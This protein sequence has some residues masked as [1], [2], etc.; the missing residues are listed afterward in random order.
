MA[1]VL[2]EQ[3]DMEDGDQ[4]GVLA[5]TLEGRLGCSR[6]CMPSEYRS[7]FV[8]ATIADQAQQAL[9]HD[10][11]VIPEARAASATILIYKTN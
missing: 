6:C 4:K 7:M 1:A 9:I 11:D 5:L 3:L 2:S 8:K 10:H